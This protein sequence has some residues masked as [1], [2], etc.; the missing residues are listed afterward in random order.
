MTSWML[1]NWIIYFLSKSSP[2]YRHFCC[3]LPHFCCVP[4]HV[5][6]ADNECADWA[7]KFTLT[8]PV[9]P[10]PVPN[11]DLQA[12]FLSPGPKLMAGILLTPNLEGQMLQWT[13]QLL[14][15]IMKWNKILT[16]LSSQGW[17]TSN[18]HFCACPVTA[19][20]LLLEWIDLDLVQQS[21]SLVALFLFYCFCVSFLDYG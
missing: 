8:Q 11:T 18:V 14:M 20:H 13:C 4:G 15:P 2:I 5:G 21:S 7:A 19:H 10:C 12:H 17:T 1:L 3:W 9:K 6:L 16:Y